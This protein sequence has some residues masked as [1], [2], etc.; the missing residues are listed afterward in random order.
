MKLGGRVLKS[1]VLVNQVKL[2]TQT[3][4]KLIGAIDDENI[5]L[6]CG[7]LGDYDDGN[8]ITVAS[9]NTVEKTTPFLHLLIIDEAH[10]A[11]NSLVYQ[12][13]ILRLREKNPNLKIVR[14]TATPFTA[15]GG[16]IF[17]QDKEIKRIT[18][19]KTLKEMIAAGFIVDPIFQSTKEGFDTSKLRKRKGDFVQKDVEKLSKDQ[20]KIKLQVADA[21]P[22]LSG[23]NKIVWSCTCIEHAELVQEEISKYEAATIIHSK[24]KKGE[25]KLNIDEFEKGSVRH[26]TSVTMVSEG[27]DYDAIHAIVNMRPMRSPVLY[28]QLCGRG[29]R[30]FPGKKDCLFLD[31]GEV[32]EALGHPNN[33]V[34]NDPKSKANKA[35]KKA[36]ICPSCEHFIFLPASHCKNCAY[37]LYKEETKP[38]DRTKKLTT[39]AGNHT[40]NNKLKKEDTIKL[41]QWTIED[42]YVS[43]AG[44][45]CLKITYMTLLNT[46][47]DYIKIGTYAHKQFVEEQSIY[48]RC[49]VKIKI[50]RDGKWTNVT[51]RFY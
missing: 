2:V 41:M 29:L 38:V 16:Y 34:V 20:E 32:V 18:Y 10:N 50:E 43:R 39:T 33:P 11:E 14:F 9:I 35:E 48:K 40:F 1:M 15:S 45:K 30:L 49:P 4:D 24:L 47:I 22:R 3:R 17:G 28:V 13:F 51:K 37:E 6:Y 27:Y 7:S 12:N 5:G 25:Q 31:Y 21:L 46:Y 26:I 42:D 23:R 8:E 19:R 44:N 36:I